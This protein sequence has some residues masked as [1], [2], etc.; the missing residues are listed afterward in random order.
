MKRRNFLALA[1]GAALAPVAFLRKP[2]PN[3][4]PGL[5]DLIDVKPL[6]PIVSPAEYTWWRNDPV[7][8]QGVRVVWDDE[9]LAA[10]MERLWLECVRDTPQP[11]LIVWST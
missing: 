4:F 10:D 11:N 2:S 1:V 3:Y 8:F 5:Y 9:K 6:G 7:Y